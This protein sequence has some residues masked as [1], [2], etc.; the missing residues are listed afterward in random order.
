MKK[1]LIILFTFGICM[2]QA[3]DETATTEDTKPKLTEE[4]RA[5]KIEAMKAEFGEEKTKD[6]IEE[7]KKRYSKYLEEYILLL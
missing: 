7:A 4:E 2:T 6:L 5:A 1:L 3:Q